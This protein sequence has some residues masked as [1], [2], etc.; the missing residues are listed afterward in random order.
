[1]SSKKVN[2]VNRCVSADFA[3]KC[4]SGLPLVLGIV[5][6]LV[7]QG[8]HDKKDIDQLYQT[9]YPQA[10]TIAIV[11]FR[12]L[13]GS[14]HLDVIAVTDEFYTELKQVPGQMQVF[15]VNRV[16]AALNEIGLDRVDTLEDMIL[17]ADQ[18]Q[19]DA[20]IAGSITRYDPYPPPKL[21]MDL[22]MYV[23][24]EPSSMVDQN[25][26][27]QANPGEIA[28]QGTSFTLDTTAPIRPQAMASRIFDAGQSDVVERIKIYAQE[29]GAKETPLGWK[30]FTA[31]RH[32]I[33]FVCH[34]MIGE[35]LMQQQTQL[36]AAP[37]APVPD[38]SSGPG[39]GD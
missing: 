19:A 4:R 28:R 18:L 32:F 30:K 22:Q 9:P 1:M 13:S 25:R 39:K 38:Y 24:P 20:V 31:S 15:P 8:C 2:R 29:R 10:Y 12:N 6:S 14:D 11:P 27:W 37:T 21:G 17:L 5:I 26:L 7:G 3:P 23:R 34:E 35:L 16:L 33:R 36:A